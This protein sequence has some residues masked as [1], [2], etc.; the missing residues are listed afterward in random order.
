MPTAVPQTSHDA[1]QVP[2]PEGGETAATPDRHTRWPLE[3]ILF[4]MAGTMTGLSA[5]LAAAVSP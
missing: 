1:P 2:D 3:R 4:L 5:I